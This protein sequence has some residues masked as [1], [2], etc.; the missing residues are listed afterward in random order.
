MT[1]ASGFSAPSP[2]AGS[3]SVPRSTARIWMTVSAERHPEQ[4]ERQVRHQ[5]GDVRRQDV[6]E[7]LADV[8]VDGPALLDG[9]DDAREVVVQQHHVGGLHGRRPSRSGPSRCRC[10][11]ARSAGASLTPSPVTATTCP[12]ACSAS[13]TRSFWSAATRAKISSGA[14]RASSHLRVGQ[15]AQ[16]SPVMTT[17]RSVW[18]RPTCRGRRRRPSAGGRR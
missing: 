5:L 18:T 10:P 1:A 12:L 4:G 3:M 16:R 9:R 17:G 7:E 14:S 8:G 11:R 15:L 2:S 6:G 13:T